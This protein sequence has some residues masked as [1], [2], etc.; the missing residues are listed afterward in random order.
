MNPIEELF[1]EI[2]TYIRQQRSNHAD[3]FEKDFR[4]FLEMS[5]DVVGSRRRVLK[6]TFV[7]LAFPLYILVNDS[8]VTIE[9]KSYCAIPIPSLLA[10]P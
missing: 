6:V 2:K 10:K 7:T 5:V 9:I 3:L 1:A 4:T 8:V